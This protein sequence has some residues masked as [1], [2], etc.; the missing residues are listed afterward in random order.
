LGW[1]AAGTMLFGVLGAAYHWDMRRILA[2][3]I[4]SQIGYI[5]L[6]VA[7]A[8]E[9]G[10]A[11]TL[12]YTLHHIVVKAN[13]FLIA[14][15]IWRLTGNYDLRKIGGL[16]KVKPLLG[17]LFLIPA[18]SLVGIP[19]LSGFWSKLLVLQEAIAQGRIAWTVIALIVSVLTLYSMVKIWMEAF[20]KPHPDEH[21]S[22][23]AY[24]RLW[25]AWLATVG[26]AAV[27]LSISLYP[28]FLVEYAQA[29]AHTLGGR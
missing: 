11:A 18:L 4:V 12:F 25:P 19:P 27:T 2:F 20:W 16:Y 26:L 14:A 8:S 17:V 6:G 3:H 13:L 9:A 28:Q 23:P 29:A 5:L 24:T 1:I 22:L 7:L 15:I 10:N 21:W